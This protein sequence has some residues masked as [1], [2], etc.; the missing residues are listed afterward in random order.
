MLRFLSLAVV[1]LACLGA[2]NMPPEADRQLAHDI[3]KEIIEIKSGFTTGAT[4]PVVEAIAS[5][6]RA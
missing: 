5:R 6:L 2:A 3:F 1:P 4:T